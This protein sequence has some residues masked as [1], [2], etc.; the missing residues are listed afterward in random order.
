MI[1]VPEVL[2][3]RSLHKPGSL[4]SILQVIGDAGVVV[5][6][7]KAIDRDH[8][9]SIW[10]ITVEVDENDDV[11]AILAQIDNLP[12]AR[13]EGRSDRVFNRHRGGKL[14]TK[15]RHR[16]KTDEELRDLYTPGVA[17]VCLAI[18]DDPRKAMEYTSLP[19][20]VG[21]VTNGTAILGL[22]NIGAVAGLPV[23]EGKAALLA[24]LV[25]LS[26]VPILIQSEDPTAI[27]DTVV[28]IAPSFGA[29][30]L[31]DIRAPE[32]FAIEAALK[33]RLNIPVMHDD[34]HGTGVVTLAALLSACRRVGIDLRRKVLGQIG[35]GAAGIGICRLLIEYGVKRVMGADLNP[36]ALA[37]LESMGGQPSDIA[38]V[39]AQADVVVSTTGVPGLIKPEMVREGQI[40]LAL[41]NPVPEL[42]PEVALARGAR[43]AA[44]GKAV[45]N[46]LGFP[47]IFLGALQARAT[48]INDAMLIAAAERLSELATGT[49]LVPNSLDRAVHASV[50]EAVRL[51]AQASNVVHT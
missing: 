47:G 50:A 5:E 28:N 24:E 16:I 12:N 43:F 13:I 48:C 3:I 1:K 35:L 22:G 9:W 7:I 31:E 30:Q 15:S 45:N 51:A 18:R 11:P 49:H 34:Q 23:M 39:M 19:H 6:G 42:E 10:E 38:D 37:Q 20:T 26:G 27:V 44:D 40:I 32:C 25:D 2:V 36:R 8:Q 21:I 4:A 41:S 46:V 14:T 17:R 33:E 29:I